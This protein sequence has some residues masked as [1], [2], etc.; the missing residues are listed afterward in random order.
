MHG[1]ASVFQKM[2][3]EYEEKHAQLKAFYMYMYAHPG[4]KLNF[5]GNEFAQ[6]RE[7]DEKREQDWNLLSYPLHDNFHR[8]MGSLN[9]IYLAHPALWARDYD[10]DGFQW[11]DCH[12]ESKCVYAFERMGGKERLA[13]VFNFSS[14][15]QTF[16]LKLENAKKYRVLLD[17]NAAYK[18]TGATGDIPLPAGGVELRLKPCTA[19]YYLVS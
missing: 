16:R 2:A 4:K 11:I 3:G 17:S 8:F 18:Q 13:A 14:R 9:R 10:R 1:K 19:I 7:W 6:V 12:Q 5:M 15:E